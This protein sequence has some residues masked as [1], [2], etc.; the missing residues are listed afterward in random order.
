MQFEKLKINI[1]VNNIAHTFYYSCNQATTFSDLIEYFAFLVPYLNICKCYQ[2]YGAKENENI[3]TQ[4]FI[5]SPQSRV[6]Q[7]KS[8]LCNIILKKNQNICQHNKFNFLLSSKKNIISYF[9]N[10]IYQ[11]DREIEQKNKRINELEQTI[12]G[13]VLLKQPS[14]GDKKDFYDIV[15]HI[16]SIKD[17]N[18]GWEIEMNDKGKENYEIYKNKN[19]LKLGVI[20]NANKGKSFLL[21]KIAKM[22]LP[23]GTS[24][25]TEGLS[26]KYPDLKLYENR[27]IVL[28]DSAGLE[29]PVLVSDEKQLEKKEKEI[30][31][32]K[33]ERNQNEKKEKN[34]ESDKNKLFREKSREKLITELF[35]QN[36]IVNN[37]DILI[38]VVDCLSYSEQK[39]L[40]KIKKEKERANK[41]TTLYVIHNL[42]TY[43]STNQV[44]EYINKTLLK[45]ATFS[46]EPGTIIDTLNQKKTGIFFTEK[47]KDQKYQNEQDIY[48]LIYANENSKAGEYYNQFT[49]DFIEQ[50]YMY[51]N[52]PGNY[53]VIKTIKER[54]IEKYDEIVEKN[55]KNEKITMDDFENSNPKLIKLKNEE[56]ITLKQCFIDE[57]GFSN[58][59]PNGFDPKYNI[60]KVDNKIIVRVEI[61]GHSTIQSDIVDGENYNYIR[62]IGNKL[63]DSEPEKLEDNIHN[64]RE[65]GPFLL[66]IPVSKVY[67]FDREDPSYE[68]VDGLHI[69]EYKLYEK[70]GPYNAP[71]QKNQKNY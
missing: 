40:M 42:K 8:V 39:L 16:D 24:I 53:D 5:I 58:L 9:Q 55:E 38:V 14:N 3:E 1:S 47:T 35:L 20:G 4:C 21:S 28:L 17:I 44:E 57:L 30:N 71:Q 18:K 34:E 50:S 10:I 54:F 2:I 29:T 43:T 6:E 61:P 41:K 33:E 23:S 36:Y 19:I 25:K 70:K 67:Q 68:Q 66:E 46:L 22:N 12:L 60:F 7:F 31:D 51:N 65:F 63:K 49:L 26:I 64:L 69:F 27:K 62:L 59:K 37:S 13:N 32:S 56:E 52:K 15:V 11:K 45:S 48:H